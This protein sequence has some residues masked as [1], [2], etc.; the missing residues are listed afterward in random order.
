MAQQEQWQLGGNAPEMYERYFVPTIFAPLA[1]LLIELA[2][3]QPSERVLD[4]ACGTGVVARLAA[5]YVGPTGQ[6]VGLDLNPEML[7]VACTI[8]LPPGAS[9]RWQEG[10]AVALPCAEAA[11]EVVCCQQGLQFF[12]DRGAALRE[13]HRVLVP[14]HS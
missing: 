9:I 3:I 8:P 10:S 4:V 11:F 7:A 6:V 2:A 5:Q 14:C 13:M 12:P 1:S